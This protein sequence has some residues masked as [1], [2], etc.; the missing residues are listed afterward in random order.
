[1]AIATLRRLTYEYPAAGRPALSGVELDLQPGLTLVTG[2]SGSGKSTLLRL[3]NG[4]VPHF[5]GGAISGAASV[6]GL[7]VLQSRPRLLARHVGFVFDDPERQ[8]VYGTVE[9][10]VAFALENV[11]LPAN[12]QAERVEEALAA[13]GIGHLRRRRIASL[14]GGERQRVALAGAIALKPELVVLDEP[15]TQLDEEGAQALACACERLLREGCSVV[16][17]EHP[18]HR[19][20]ALADRELLVSGGTV[21]VV[22]AC[23]QEPRAA[24]AREPRSGLVRPHGGTLVEARGLAVGATGTAVIQAVGFQLRGGEVVA[25]RGPNGS[26]K[27]TLMRTLAG[28]LR[29]LAGSVS[30]PVRNIAYLPQNPSALLHQPTLAQ[31]VNLTLLR[32]GTAERAD[33]ILQKLDLEHAAGRYPRD[34]SGG[35]RQRAAIAAVLAGAPE[36]VFLDEPTRGM[37]PDARGRLACLLQQLAGSGSGVVVATH[38]QLLAG[39]VANRTLVIRDGR[40]HEE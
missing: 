29:P 7:D 31:E 37:D 23:G 19:L 33:D 8:F 28:L 35:E 15:A 38:D 6:L 18:P 27:T 12:K 39:A 25:L 13:I 32:R 30:R 9:R 20:A 1:M 16:V 22:A 21:A 14:S 36:L 3:L 10:D 40:V 17:A 11:G 4:L 26:G 24:P 34:L 2:A 5:H